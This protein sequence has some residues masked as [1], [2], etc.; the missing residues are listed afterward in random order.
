MLSIELQSIN[1]AYPL[2]IF[3]MFRSKIFLS[4][5]PRLYDSTRLYMSS[6]LSL[7]GVP[8]KLP[9]RIFGIEREHT[10]QGWQGEVQRIQSENGKFWQR[11]ISAH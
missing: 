6:D 10:S 4:M 3:L 5:V 9:P 11:L 8:Q 7:G 1:S 2:F